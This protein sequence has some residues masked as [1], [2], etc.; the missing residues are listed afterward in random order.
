M[1]LLPMTRRLDSSPKMT[2]H[3][4]K[5]K[6]IPS[7]ICEPS[8]EVRNFQNC[9]V[10]IQP[11]FLVIMVAHLSLN[12]VSYSGRFRNY[13]MFGSTQRFL[14]VLNYWNSAIKF[15]LYY[16][17][18]LNS[19]YR[20]KFDRYPTLLKSLISF[21]HWIERDLPTRT[22]TILRLTRCKWEICFPNGCSLTR[23]GKNSLVIYR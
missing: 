20:V 13:Q 15:D 9:K 1:R 19:Y 8:V 10:Y 11:L 14:S 5:N 22:K 6:S 7:L 21:H 18:Y 17:W 12:Q 23:W 16:T 3:P 4:K 2:L